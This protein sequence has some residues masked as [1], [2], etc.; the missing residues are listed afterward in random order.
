MKALDLRTSK[1][2]IVG[3][4]VNVLGSIL[5]NLGTVSVWVGG[6]GAV[7]VHGRRLVCALP[8]RGAAMGIVQK[9]RNCTRG[10][11]SAHHLCSAPC[12]PRPPC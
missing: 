10:K 7:G 6:G 3:A 5:I 1:N 9:K 11:G 8:A 2:W 4:V 12:T